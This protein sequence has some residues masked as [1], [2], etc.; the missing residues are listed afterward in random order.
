MQ[1]LLHTFKKRS[2]ATARLLIVCLGFNMVL[3]TAAQAAQAVPA[4]RTTVH[5]S[6][7]DLA[8]LHLPSMAKQ[9]MAEKKAAQEIADHNKK[10]DLKDK[11][12]LKTVK[13]QE[14]G[15]VEKMKYIYQILGSRAGQKPETVI[16]DNVHND[17]ETYCGSR[18]TPDHNLLKALNHTRTA[19]GSV[20]LQRMLFEATSDINEL[21][22]RQNIVK[23]LLEDET[24]FNQV[25]TKLENYKAAEKDFLWLWKEMDTEIEKYFEQAY[26]G[27]KFFIDFSSFNKNEVLLQMVGTWTLANPVIQGLMPVWLS[28]SIYNTF[29]TLYTKAFDA[30]TREQFDREFGKENGFN[31]YKEFLKVVKK[32]FIE[33]IYKSE[34]EVEFFGQKRSQKVLVGDRIVFG[35]MLAGFLYL[36]YRQTNTAINDATTFNNV[37]N[38]IHRRMNSA[39]V[40]TNSVGDI[41]QLV[42]RNSTLSQDLSANL[43]AVKNAYVFSG[44]NARTA[45]LLSTLRSN[46]F[47]NEPSLVAFKGRAMAAFKEIFDVK[48]NLVGSMR[49]IGEIDAFMSVAK[50]YKKFANHN[51]VTFCFVDY[52]NAKTPYL[53][54]SDFW[55]PVLNP[56]KAVPNSITLGRGNEPKNAVVTGPNAGGKSTALKSITVCVMLAQSFGIAPAR[57]MTMTPFALVNTYMNIA[58]TEG[59]ESLFQAE[60]HRAQELLRQVRS[61]RNDQF[62]FVI[63]DEIFTGTNP[64]E[65]QAA[66]YGIAKKLA[67]YNNSLAILATHFIVMTDLASDTVED[68]TPTGKFEN[69]KVYIERDE[70]NTITFPY[71]LEKGITDQAIALDLL[72]S[73]GFD[74]D[75]LQDAFDVMNNKT[76]AQSERIASNR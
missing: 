28:Y 62:S 3:A 50:L 74:D 8:Q 24:L 72:Q 56:N 18:T 69:F 33:T 65:G 57:A 14:M 20:E 66:A 45:E 58:D 48:D 27:K 51:N 41:A 6:Y 63:M 7:E 2:A 26:C 70:Y 17:L 25:D 44:S 16:S 12:Q 76:Q 21:K 36:Y 49:S 15:D 67:T 9:E 11:N 10:L 60:M 55:H 39:A 75:I 40:I 32:F 23:A 29:N 35:S 71:K 22:R 61:L 1:H 42:H 30:H 52:I 37:S 19:V 47:K 53:S 38:D 5:T 46:T 34:I 59:K 68:K 4:V 31:S 73:E 64:K 54:I 13:V 43:Q